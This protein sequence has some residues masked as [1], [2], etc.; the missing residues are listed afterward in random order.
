MDTSAVRR[1][2][3]R[4]LSEKEGNEGERLSIIAR[5][6]ALN[7]IRGVSSR[8]EQVELLDVAGFDAKDA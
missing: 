2:M 6:L 5:L 8:Q 7:L 1:V 4:L 3:G